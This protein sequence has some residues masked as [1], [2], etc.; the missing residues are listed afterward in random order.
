M[1]PAQHLGKLGTVQK[2]DKLPSRELKRLVRVNSAGN[3]DGTVRSLSRHD[4]VKLTRGL[5]AD[6]ILAPARALDEG[7][8]A[9]PL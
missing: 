3:E 2:V 8:L 7:C 1:K 4:T 9:A 5:H 6:F